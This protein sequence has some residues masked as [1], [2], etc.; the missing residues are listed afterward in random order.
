MD[1]ESETQRLGQNQNKYET[2]IKKEKKK[3]SWLS[4]NNLKQPSSSCIYLNTASPHPVTSN[5]T[6]IYVSEE[7]EI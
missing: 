4:K 1:V 7:N 6:E 2:Q 3:E 5:P